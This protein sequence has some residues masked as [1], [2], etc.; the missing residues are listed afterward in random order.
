M[1]LMTSHAASHPRVVQRFSQPTA[2]AQVPLSSSSSPRSLSDRH[3]HRQRTEPRHDRFVCRAKRVESSDKPTFWDPTEKGGEAP[4]SSLAVRPR[5]VSK[6]GENALGSARHVRVAL[7]G[8][9]PPEV[10]PL[11]SLAN[12][13]IS[14]VIS[15]VMQPLDVVKPLEEKEEEEEDGRITLTV[16]GMHA[17]REE[18]RRGPRAL[19]QPLMQA[20]PSSP[21]PEYNLNLLER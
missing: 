13:V 8:T 2:R 9:E 17:F 16:P 19:D 11:T 21:A 10:V 7:A 18:G 14:P 6:T 5:S 1:A 20:G 4:G 12:S 15:P 3:T